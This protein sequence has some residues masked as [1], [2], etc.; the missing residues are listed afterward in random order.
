ME[1]NENNKNP[2]IW[3]LFNSAVGK[4]S[5]KMTYQQQFLMFP[6]QQ[7]RA[8]RSVHKESDATYII[9]NAFK[10]FSNYLVHFIAQFELYFVWP[11]WLILTESVF[12]F[13]LQN[14]LEKRLN[15][16]EDLFEKPQAPQVLL[17]VERS[18]LKQE[19]ITLNMVAT[20]LAEDNK[21]ITQE[22]LYYKICT[23]KTTTD[24]VKLSLLLPFAS[25]PEHLMNAQLKVN[26]QT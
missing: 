11:E 25:F 13:S 12:D 2:K 24:I 7:G 14:D 17:D 3:E 18:R 15:C 20:K 9:Q 23:E 5:E 21:N 1:A 4:I 16:L 22:S 6:T 8:S 10:D 19:F 26:F